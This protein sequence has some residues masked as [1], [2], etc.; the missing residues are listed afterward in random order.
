MSETAEIPMALVEDRGASWNRLAMGLVLV[1]VGAA[2]WWLYAK[3][4]ADQGLLL[5]IRFPAAHGLKVEDPVKLN[6][7]R[8]GT[9]RK[10][11][12]T[13]DLAGVI[14][15]VSLMGPSSSRARIAR[16]GSRFWIVRADFS[17]TQIRGSET[18][19]GANYIE[20]DPGDG[21]ACRVFEGLA[22][23][24]AIERR[25]AGD[26]PVTLVSAAAPSAQVGAPVLYRDLPIGQVLSID[27]ASSGNEVLTEILV[28]TRFAGLVRQRSRFYEVE[29][30]DLDVGLRGVRVTAG[31]L[32]AVLRG[33]VGLATPG[34]SEQGATASAGQRF[35]LYGQAEEAWLNWQPSVNLAQVPTLSTPHPLECE[36]SWG[37]G[38]GWKKVFRKDGMRV[39]RVLQVDSG[40]LGPSD[41]F[42][43]KEG[44]S[45]AFVLEVA[46]QFLAADSEHL[47]EGNGLTLLAHR[48]PLGIPWAA[49][50]IRV[51]GEIEDIMIY[52]TAE[53][54]SF[55][56]ADGLT[57][58][59][60]RWRLSDSELDA[61][62]HGAAVL[63]AADE[64]LV[65]V[66]LVE[67]DEVSVALL[68]DDFPR[69]QQ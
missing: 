14:A 21:P 60:R 22:E 57:G 54:S 65:G 63:A 46:G 43:P 15:T 59:G 9:V 30:F 35:V 24:P 62:W 16:Q 27:L 45:D 67:D 12:I 32:A 51:T 36:M 28:Y 47:W 6:D 53:V 33:G 49:R 20:V 55:V 42:V 38:R 10:L 11:E 34:P 5:E 8:V 68:P 44:W 13:E 4:V 61:G 31:S 19:I 48:E 66:L 41:L 37:R 40:L 26:L 2:A 23:P 39:G 64:M 58:Q 56:S 25:G 7:V 3:A 52:R 18:L 17:L 1:C 50:A 69:G 29:A